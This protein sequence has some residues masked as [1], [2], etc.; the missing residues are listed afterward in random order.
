MKFLLTVQLLLLSLLLM[1]QKSNFNKTSS[2]NLA[3]GD[4]EGSL[5]ILMYHTFGS[6]K[7]NRFHVGVGLRYTGYLGLNRYF[8]T[9]PAELTSESTSPTIIFKNNITKNIDSL[10]VK[11][12]FA[13]SLN[14]A[15]NFDYRLHKKIHIG[16]NIDL[17]GFS[18]GNTSAGNYING[19]QGKNTTATPSGFNLL[20]VSDNDVG[21]LNSEFYGTYSINHK[22]G[23]KLA[24][25]FLFVEYTT[26]IKVQTMPKENDRFRYKSFLPSIGITYTF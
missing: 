22:W 21:S 1:A 6:S 5:S 4:Q 20:L 10:I 23:V 12:A 13:H 17:F 25:Q 24:A 7:T 11:T 3:L 15:V 26:A 14:A 19:V 8:I 18:L 2:I 9:A 16:F